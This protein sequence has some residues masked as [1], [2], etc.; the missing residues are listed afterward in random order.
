MLVINIPLTNPLLNVK[1]NKQ[2]SS[3]IMISYFSRRY[4]GNVIWAIWFGYLC[5]K[6][7]TIFLIRPHLLWTWCQIA[8]KFIMERTLR[9]YR[10]PGVF[11]ISTHSSLVKT[12]TAIFKALPILSQTTSSDVF[13]ENNYVIGTRE[14]RIFVQCWSLTT[15]IYFTLIKCFR[16]KALHNI[17]T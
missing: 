16:K 11:S 7:E 9:N 12:L 10:S 15:L 17:L 8:V 13:Q 3:E 4:Y 5:N 14:L 6:Y 1:W 2:D